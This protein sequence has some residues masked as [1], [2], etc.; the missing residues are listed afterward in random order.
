CGC[1]EVAELEIGFSE[2]TPGADRA[3]RR[4]TRVATAQLRRP[5]SLGHRHARQPRDAGTL[6]AAGW[7]LLLID[8]RCQFF[9]HV[10]SVPLESH[11][12]RRSVHP[13]ANSARF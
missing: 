11:Q 3:P 5:A 1:A 8:D 12:N 4:D 9:H 10:L 2:E 7:V 13:T 6:A